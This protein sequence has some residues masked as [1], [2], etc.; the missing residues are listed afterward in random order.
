ML[1]LEAYASANF[2]TYG[3]KTKINTDIKL[4]NDKSTS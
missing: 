4:L 3:P 2:T 1:S